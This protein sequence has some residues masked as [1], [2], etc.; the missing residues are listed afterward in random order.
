MTDSYAS[1]KTVRGIIDDLESHDQNTIP[2]QHL[3]PSGKTIFTN[4]QTGAT[5]KYISKTPP[6]DLNGNVVPDERLLDK[7]SW[8]FYP[9]DVEIGIDIFDPSQGNLW[10][11]ERDTYIIYVYN[12][13]EISDKP[14]GWYA[15]TEKKKG[16]DYFVIQTADDP[17]RDLVLIGESDAISNDTYIYGDDQ[18]APLVLKQG[19]LYYNTISNDLFVWKGN[20]DEYG[21]VPPGQS[22]DEG[23]WIQITK[24]TEQPTNTDIIIKTSYDLLRE[25]VEVL[26][27]RVAALS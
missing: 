22:Q 20:M 13:G 6:V 25:R 2:P 8:V 15:L 21:N 10:V 24:Q 1:L 5:Y 14:F 11:D 12:N 19:F 3:D 27:A 7:N 9:H 17:E 16:Y 18:L 26:E 23:S 4:P